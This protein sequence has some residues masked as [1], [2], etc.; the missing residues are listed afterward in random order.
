YAPLG[1]VQRLRQRPGE[2]SFSLLEIAPGLRPAEV[3]AKVAHTL[4]DLR[5][6]TLAA[7]RAR[8]TAAAA[9]LRLVARSLSGIGSAL[10]AAVVFLTLWSTVSERSADYAV[11]RAMGFGPR[12]ILV[13]V[14]CQAALLGGAGAL[15]GA[16]AGSA[17][18]L[19]IVSRV[20]PALGAWPEASAI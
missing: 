1:V 9:P 10:A 14:L 2:L 5:V 17:I 13:D 12:A 7:A 18:L 6:L 3:E 19:G 11:L 4:T 8:A 20:H 16:I 15:V